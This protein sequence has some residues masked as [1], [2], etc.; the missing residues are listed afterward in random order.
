MESLRLAVRENACK[1]L[2]WTNRQAFLPKERTPQGF[3]R[4]Q[5]RLTFS[6]VRGNLS[7]HSGRVLPPRGPAL[8][9]PPG[10]SP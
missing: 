6:A 10:I 7:D 8:E 4:R 9:H 2:A 1:Q 3:P 5:S